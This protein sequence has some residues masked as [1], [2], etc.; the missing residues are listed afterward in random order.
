ME[1]ALQD[2]PDTTGVELSAWRNSITKRHGLRP[3]HL[4]EEMVQNLLQWS[5]MV[6]VASWKD[7]SDTQVCISEQKFLGINTLT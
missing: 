4:V 5:A 7:I 3:D 6:K 2:G 1:A